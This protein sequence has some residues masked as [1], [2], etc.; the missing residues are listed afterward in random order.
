MNPTELLSYVFDGVEGEFAVFHGDQ[1]T[2]LTVGAPLPEGAETAEL[3]ITAERKV[4]GVPVDDF[5]KATFVVRKG[6]QKVAYILFED[7]VPEDAIPE[8]V[9]HFDLPISEGWTAEI[10][11]DTFY[12]F[13]EVFGVSE[14]VTENDTEETDHAEADLED[15]DAVGDV[16]EE[17]DDLGAGG[18]AEGS[19][20]GGPV[21]GGVPVA[22]GHP[23]GHS[24]DADPEGEPEDEAIEDDGE[25]ELFNDAELLGV[26]TPAYLEMLNK[27][28]TL[29]LGEMWGAKDR[30][31]TQD[32]HWNPVTLPWAAW[33][34]GQEGTK[35]TPAWG[36]SRHPENREKAGACVVL[37]SSIGK[38]R[39]A[40]AMET[41]YAMGIDIDSGAKLD[42]VLTFIEG[43]GLFCLVYTSHSHGKSGLQLKYDDVIRKL[44]IKPSELN[45]A[46]VQRY[47]RDY[48]KNRYEEDF[49]AGVEIVD[50]KKQV[51]DGIVIDLKTPALDKYRLI[52]PL[53][54]PV[55]LIELGET[56]AEALDRW[57]DSITGLAQ[58]MLG[59]HFDTSCT[60]PSRLFYT[61]RHPK[62][63]DD[64]YCAIVRGDPLRFADVKPMKKSA[65]TKMRVTSDMNA[66]E[67]AGGAFEG[68]RIP[69]CA[70]PSGKSLND[71][72]SKAGKRFQIA[73]LL[74][75]YCSDRIRVAG[76]EASGQVHIECPF[77]H[78]HS[79]EGGTAT[80]AINALESSSEYW[81]IFCQHDACQGRHKLE[82]LEEML[83]QNWFDEELL[84]GDSVYLLDGEDETDE[85]EAAQEEEEEESTEVT[86][87]TFAERAADFTQDTTEEEVDQLIKKA[88]RGGVDRMEKGRITNAIVKH[89]PL[90]KRDVTAKWKKLEKDKADRAKEKAE[91]SG[92]VEAEDDVALVNEWHFADMCKFADRRIKDTNA[93]TPHVFH[94]MESLCVIRET[95]EGHARMKFLDKDGFAHMLNTVAPF[96]KLSG[97]EGTRKGVSAPDDVVRHLYAADYGTYPELR[98]LVTT[99]IFTQSGG[100]LV[101]PGYDDDSRLYYKPD[102]TLSVP[103][104]PKK[105]TE[106]DIAKAKQLLIEEILADFPLGGLTRPEIVDRGLHGEG[107]PAVANSIALILLPF[108]REL[109]DGPTP[110]HLLTKPT[111]GTGASLLT[112][113]ISI[114]S[115]GREASALA[116]PT[117]KD[118]MSK[119]LTSVLSDGQN[120]VFFD[121]INHSVDSGELAS[122]MTANTYKARILGKSQTVEVAVR[123]S[124]IFTG[125]NVTL[126]NELL[127]RLIMIDLDARLA[128]P[129]MRTGFRHNDVRGWAKEN[130]GDLV[131]ACLTLIQN[132]IASGAEPQ[133]DQVLA[134]YENWS[135]AVGGV[136]KAAGI[137]GF[138]GNRDMLKEKAADESGDSF[139]FL[140]EAWWNA[141]GAKPAYVKGVS[142]GSSSDLGIADVAINEDVS[143]P[144]RKER[145]NDGDQAYN[146]AG[147]GRFLAGYRDRVFNLEDG[148]EVKITRDNKRTSRGYQWKLEIQ[149]RPSSNVSV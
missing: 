44:K 72:H 6:D 129:E 115:T 10:V 80:M 94:Y 125:N 130:R 100:M 134:S 46:Q 61:A 31:N 18:P 43:Q 141:F 93:K 120:I 8:H 26:E 51:K 78:E 70:T 86:Q 96:A 17:P 137:G 50:M 45:L 106:D 105:P 109:I 30:R 13:D 131:W 54:E 2:L 34:V 113:V 74:E 82:F 132:W 57:E 133:K 55:K 136:L 148:T 1:E 81:T 25:V 15:E 24:G 5:T 56:H 138:M 77:E 140:L 67:V 98:G 9:A 127:R 4:V 108:M 146:M 79:S 116:M 47:L 149:N 59:V 145:D 102:M 32:E 110:G 40:K 97:D 117:N 123:C 83:R 124:W 41:M 3:V 7:P 14:G 52:F 139:D 23:A 144:V 128:N 126:S 60:D 58:N 147:F 33:I 85:E 22:G 65:Y 53:E 48:D 71:W 76:G 21:A 111:P 114:I 143:L 64:W 122:A 119:T 63:S 73:D 19:D 66:F 12:T 95:S 88:F 37:G 16:G 101:T 107:V 92:E 62:N 118:E 49:I 27:P 29:M 135:G 69:Q 35:N 89:T 87:K 91:K 104:I 11:T 142:D 75:D 99:P 121:N 39:K 42:D 20:G 90:S 36:F 68:D 38:A 28:A 112:E 103:A 84:F